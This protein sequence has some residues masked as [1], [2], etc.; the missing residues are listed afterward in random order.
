ML[1]Q[2]L[3]KG[4]LGTVICVSG[5]GVFSASTQATETI[6]QFSTPILITQAISQP[7][8]EKFAKAI[9][10]LQAIDEE[11]RSKMIEAVQSNGMSPEEFMEIGNKEESDRNLS[12]EKQDQFNK[13]LEAVRNLHEQDRQKKR[14]AVEEAGLKIPRFNEIAKIVEDDSDLKKQVIEILS[15]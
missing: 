5:L 1:K 3:L 9:V 13:A 6:S 2:L 4:C 8:L 7:E 11:T 14:V 12:E 15:R 10:D